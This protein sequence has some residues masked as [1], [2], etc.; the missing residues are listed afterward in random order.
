MELALSLEK[1]V[2]EK[3]LNLHNVKTT[4]LIFINLKI[5]FDWD[6]VMI[7][8]Q[9]VASKNGDVH[10]ADFIESEFLTEQV[11]RFSVLC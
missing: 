10:L 11:K 4:S 3:L 9:Q 5:L 1:L 7:C 2:N 8:V 6:L